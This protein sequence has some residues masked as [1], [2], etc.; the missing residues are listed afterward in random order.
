MM[1]KMADLYA[2]LAPLVI[3][4]EDVWHHFA[5]LPNKIQM[6]VGDCAG[7]SLERGQHFT[8]KALSRDEVE[9]II[10]AETHEY[11]A[12]VPLCEIRFR[13][14]KSFETFRASGLADETDG[15]I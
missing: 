10:E 3:S 13:S 9:E 1:A 14:L 7:Y 15:P 12:R 6:F 4:E 2:Y 5:N 11:P 8:L